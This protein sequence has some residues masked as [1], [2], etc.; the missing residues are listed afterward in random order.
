[1]KKL[2][3]ILSAIIFITIFACDRFEHTFYTAPTA[4]ITAEPLIGYVPLQVTFEDISVLGS[5]PIEEWTWDFDGDSIPD[6]TYNSQNKPD[7]I[8]HVF[9]LPG[10][11]TVSMTINDGETTTSETIIIE[12][13]NINS[14]FANFTYTPQY[15][16]IPLDVTFTD[17]STSGTNPITN[18]EWD[19]NDDGVIDSNEQNPSYT[20]DNA[21]DYQITLTVFDGTYENSYSETITI[22]AKSVVI[23]MFTAISCVNCP[24]VEDALHNLKEEYGSKLSYV[25]YHIN[26]VLD[27]GNIPL[28][29][30]YES[31]GLLPYTVINGNAEIITGSSGTIQQEIEDII[32]PLMEQSVL[33]KLIDGQVSI[34]GNILSGSVQVE[35]DGSISL[36]N[37]TLVA[38]LSEKYSTEHQN[39]SGE[40]LHNIELKRET[41]N[42]SSLNLQDPVEFTIPDLDQLALGY[43]QLPEDLILT[44]WIQTLEDPYNENT[45]TIHNVIEIEI[46][47]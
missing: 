21:G 22:L 31:T 19:F 7:S 28:M 9:E 37:L 33:A 27:P 47:R 1:M 14:P 11:F 29:V 3:L 15:G 17:V 43:E 38:V 25:E 40:N 24:I 4:K 18:W 13:L 12:V 5:R 36:D 20:Y 41:V 26:D 46:I 16:Y 39:H 2:L 23:E 44:L 34:N 32:T 8:V 45:C 30:Y 42:I 6:S 10:T 35:L